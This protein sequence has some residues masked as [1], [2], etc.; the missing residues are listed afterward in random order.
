MTGENPYAPPGALS[1]D[2]T[3]ARAR[4][5]AELGRD[6]I[7]II[8][9]CEGLTGILVALRA[10]AG[11]VLSS[12]PAVQIVLGLVYRY[13]PLTLSL[14]VLLALRFARGA[15]SLTYIGEALPPD[16][17]L[18]LQLV[19]YQT[20][21]RELAWLTVMAVVLLAAPRANE[22]G[23]RR[24]WWITIPLMG[25]AVVRAATSLWAN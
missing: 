5:P 20:I 17:P 4:G 18:E 2:E 12:F 1:S 6:F 9:V 8:L 24:L 13:R 21:F 7:A 19:V 15:Y 3:A 11:L 22:R 16:S 14:L 23:Q 25:W 10:E